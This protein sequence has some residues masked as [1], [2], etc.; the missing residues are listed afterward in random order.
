[1]TAIWMRAR[2][3]LRTGKRSIV[4]L[5]LVIGIFGGVAMASAA[6]ARRTDSA[7]DRFIAATTPPTA[8]VLSGDR[9]SSP[10]FP[11]VPLRR[12]RRLPQVEKSAVAESLFGEALTP[13]GKPL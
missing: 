12:A 4:A 11:I 6:G 3:E 7:Y 9:A 1:M 8:F 2:S 10:Q 5:A 13:S